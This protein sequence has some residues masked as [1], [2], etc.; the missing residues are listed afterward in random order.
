MN[1]RT[2]ELAITSVTGHLMGVDFDE[3]YRR[4][5]SCN[6]AQLLDTQVIIPHP[7]ISRAILV[8]WLVPKSAQMIHFSLPLPLNRWFFMMMVMGDND[9]VFCCPC[10]LVLHSTHKLYARS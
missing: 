6:P 3:T 1:G 9:D 4:W 10:L 2:V 5:T 7:P 8:S